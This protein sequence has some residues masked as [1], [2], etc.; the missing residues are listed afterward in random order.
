MVNSK[1]FETKRRIDFVTCILYVK[2]IHKADE[3]LGFH[4]LLDK[5]REKFTRVLKKKTEKS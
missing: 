4:S 2:S 5:I 1:V 3:S